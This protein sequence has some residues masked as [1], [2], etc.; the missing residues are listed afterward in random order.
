MNKGGNMRF[1]KRILPSLILAPGLVLLI[2]VSAKT[3][4]K[5]KADNTIQ[6]VRDRDVVNNPTA[7]D[8]SNRR[9]DVALTAK[10]RRALMSDANLSMDAK[11]IKIIDRHG[12]VLLRGPVASVR[13][14]KVIE[15]LAQQYCGFNYKSELDVKT[16]K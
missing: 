15:R 2:L 16:R 9:T 4:E 1:I 5:F 7:E 14:K 8:Q 12:C 3:Q 11:N 10:L 13:E 6:N